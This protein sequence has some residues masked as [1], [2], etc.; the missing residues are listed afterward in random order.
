MHAPSV[1]VQPSD[2]PSRPRI[3]VR[4]MATGLPSGWGDVCDHPV[5]SRRAAGA[6]L[7]S[8][9]S[10]S[11]VQWSSVLC[12]RPHRWRS[13]SVAPRSTVPRVSCS[14]IGLPLKL[15]P[16][17]RVQSRPIDIRGGPYGVP[18]RLDANSI[19]DPT[20]TVSPPADF[21]RAR[22]PHPTQRETL[23]QIIHMTSDK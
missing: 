2:A 1:H 5:V 7:S 20:L 6:G 12:L 4:S 17:P 19:G 8:V 18:V 22:T 9:L 23:E 10:L 21:W 15:G 16:R 14:L 3:W 13:E 11:L